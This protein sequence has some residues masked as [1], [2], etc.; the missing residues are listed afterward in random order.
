MV[1]AIETKSKIIC[2]VVNLQLGLLHTLLRILISIFKIS[3][4]A[5]LI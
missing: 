2:H 3:V 5:L 4:F 1:A